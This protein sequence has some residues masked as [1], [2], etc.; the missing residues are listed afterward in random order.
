MRPW[1]CEVLSAD[2]DTLGAA[3]SADCQRMKD[4][5]SVG[6]WSLEDLDAELTERD[7]LYGPYVRELPDGR[8]Q[9]FAFYRNE[10]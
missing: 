5:Y 10:E 8:R 6:A 9:F 3:L 1:D 4:V 7:L 2:E